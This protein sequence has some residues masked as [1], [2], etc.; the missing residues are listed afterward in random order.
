MKS[1]SKKIGILFA[2]KVSAAKSKEE[3]GEIIKTFA[4]NSLHCIDCKEIFLDSYLSQ[5]E[6]KNILL[7]YPSLERHLKI[8]NFV[9]YIFAQTK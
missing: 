7:K 5:E 8:P 1:S 6:V 4:Q 9:A 2:K 3:A